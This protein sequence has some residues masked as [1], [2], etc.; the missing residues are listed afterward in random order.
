[1]T[2]YALIVAALAVLAWLW[3]RRGLAEPS[4]DLE[5]TQ[6]VLVQAIQ[7]HP[8]NAELEVHLGFVDQK[9]GDVE[10]AQKAFEQAV[11]DDPKKAEAFYMLGL[12]YEKKGMNA[13]ALQAWKSCLASAKEPG[14]RQ[15]AQK[16]LHL[17]ETTSR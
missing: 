14:M 16:H 17:L 13:Q 10:G 12:I 6:Q 9:L 7:A 4:Q 2:R 11:K 8:G 1:M 15:T 5:V 3:P